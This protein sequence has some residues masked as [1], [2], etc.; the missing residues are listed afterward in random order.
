[1]TNIKLTIEYTTKPL[2]RISSMMAAMDL[3]IEEIL[4]DPMIITYTTKTKVDK[5]YKDRLIKMMKKEYFMNADIS[6]KNI[7]M[8]IIKTI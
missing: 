1:M 4:P 7:K 6:I 8:E 5:K 3:G 2:Q